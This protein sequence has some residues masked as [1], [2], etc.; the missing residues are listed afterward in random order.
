MGDKT[1]V[2]ELT[3]R[4]LAV[5][6]SHFAT[7]KKAIDD[8]QKKLR[9]EAVE[10]LQR[11]GLVKQDKLVVDPEFRCARLKAVY[12]RPSMVKKR[13]QGMLEAHK[14]GFRFQNANK[15]R[16]EIMYNNIKNA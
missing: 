5:N 1:F 11:K 6:G 8:I 10:T 15:E 14:N 4:A 16:V 2:K 7:I 9:A 13:V 12:M 3:F